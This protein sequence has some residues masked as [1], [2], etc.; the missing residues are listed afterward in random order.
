MINKIKYD[1]KEIDISKSIHIEAEL[2]DNKKEININKE[3]FSRIQETK[4][5]DPLFKEC[6]N[7]NTHNNK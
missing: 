2:F 7:K 3:D 5:T 4:E 6:L 1:C